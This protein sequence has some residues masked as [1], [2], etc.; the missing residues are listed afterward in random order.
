MED[1][2]PGRVFGEVAGDYDRVRPSYPAAVFD[3]VVSYGRAGMHDLRALEVGAGTGRA[4]EGFAARGLPVVAVE[5]DGAMAEV[6]ARRT[7][8]FPG[9]RIVLG[10]FEEFRTTE[11]FS[12]LFSAEAWHWTA[13]ETRWSRAAELL[14]GGGA[15]ALFWNNERVADS[16]LRA[17]M[18][19]VFARHAPSVVINDKPVTSQQVWRQW[20]GDELSGLAE[21]EDLTSRH[22]QTRRTMPAADYLGLTQTRSQFRM[23]PP[24]VREELLAALTR[25]FGDAVP[26][27]VHTTLLLARRRA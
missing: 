25:L 15:L 4:T 6:L 20:P 23:L 24:S 14:S 1:R 13:A 3:D 27:A 11:Q 9:V 5:P 17:S 16:A 10:S 12:L 18:L 21:F 26:L 22:Y 8:R 7:A 2:K 19:R